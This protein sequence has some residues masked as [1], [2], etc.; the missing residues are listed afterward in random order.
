M[1]IRRLTNAR[2]MWTAAGF[3]YTQNQ[4]G[5]FIMADLMASGTNPGTTYTIS[6]VTDPGVYHEDRMVVTEVAPSTYVTQMFRVYGATFESGAWEFNPSTVSTAY[7]TVQNPDG[8]IHY[9]S[10]S[11]ATGWTTPEWEGSSDVQPVK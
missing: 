7:A 2:A 6:P 9:Y 8:S 3:K 10:Y 11:G 4:K 1:D 5:D